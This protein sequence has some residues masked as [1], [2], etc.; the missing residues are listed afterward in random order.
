MSYS[1][2]ARDALK[3]FGLEKTALNARLV[4]LLSG[5]ALGAGL[6][7]EG[8]G[9]QGAIVGAGAGFGVGAGLSRAGRR[10]RPAAKPVMKT[11]DFRGGVNFR[12]KDF[13][14]GF[15]TGVS[16]TRERMMGMGRWVPRSV[17]ERTISGLDGGLDAQAI[18][19][20][21][22][23]RGRYLQPATGAALGAGAAY[24]AAPKA[25]GPAGKILGALVGAGAGSL[26]HASKKGQRQADV[27]E[28]LRGIGTEAMILNRL[29][30]EAS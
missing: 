6:A 25:V 23:D 29:R 15:S 24:F 3:A 18:K 10:L 12:P 2:G 26:L 27:D 14:V 28:A 30:R 20:L 21:E 11:A 17:I 19:E 7:R 13:P 8:E 22:A 1:T 5:T 16:D 4:G 9:V